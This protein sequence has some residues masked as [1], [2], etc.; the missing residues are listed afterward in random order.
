MFRQLLGSCLCQKRSGPS[1]DDHGPKPRLV[2]ICLYQGRPRAMIDP[3]GFRSS[4][5]CQMKC[6]IAR[7]STIGA[8]QVCC[9]YR[10]STHGLGH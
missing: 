4:N 2:A 8:D 5:G 1:R 6:T 9:H 7:G 3:D 10:Q